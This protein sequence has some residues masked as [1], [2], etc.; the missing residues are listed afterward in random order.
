MLTTGTS[1]APASR[2]TIEWCEHARRDHRVVAL[3]D[4]RD[5]LDR[6][7]DVEADLL[8]ARVDGMTA[9]LHDGDLHRL[10]GAVRRLL[11]DQRRRPG[12][13]AGDRAAPSGRSARSSTWRSSS[14][15]RSVMSSRIAR[16][17]DRVLVRGRSRRVSPAS[18]IS[19]SVTVSGGAKRS[20]VGVDG[21]ADQPAVEQP[22]RRRRGR[23]CLRRAGRRAAVRA[24]R[25]DDTPGIAEPVRRTS[26]RPACA[27]APARRC[28]ASR[29]SPRTTAAVAIAVPL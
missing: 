23:R 3:H 20:V 2:S 10:T 21:V 27:P 5:V 11:E 15:V 4:P 16:R 29:R 26:A 25:T 17:H 6:F 18:S 24:P 12:R 9:E 14:A 8:A 1:T 7:A 22:R 28:G 19:S 13:R